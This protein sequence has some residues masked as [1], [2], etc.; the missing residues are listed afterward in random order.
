MGASLTNAEDFLE[1]HQQ[2]EQDIRVRKTVIVRSIIW[3][4]SKQHTPEC[5]SI[6]SILEVKIYPYLPILF[7][8][9]KISLSL[10]IPPQPFHKKPQ[11]TNMSYN[12]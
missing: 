11:Q 2:L 4:L 8:Q 1:V 3:L 10:T 5:L 6:R 9:I 12:A 7:V